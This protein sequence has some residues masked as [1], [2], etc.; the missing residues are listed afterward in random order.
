MIVYIGAD[1]R[2]F[3]LKEV[4]K[5]FLDK[6]GYEI[7][8]L[9]NH[10]YD[11]NDDY[12]DYAAKVARK[13]YK[14][15]ESRGILL[16]GSGVGVD[17]VANRFKRVRSVL[18]CGVRQVIAS[19][20]DDDTNVLSIAADFTSERQAKRYVEV[21]LKTPFSNAPRHKRRIAKIDKVR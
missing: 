1:H 6:K 19:R 9:G 4:L 16:C 7:E 11:P 21:W 12:P 14:N 18:A 15:P 3:K 10:R 20:N 5:R 17:I 8:D 2:G 13:I